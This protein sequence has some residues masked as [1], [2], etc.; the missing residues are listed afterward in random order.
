MREGGEDAHKIYP[1]KNYLKCKS[2]HILDHLSLLCTPWGSP[3]YFHIWWTWCFTFSF[4][5]ARD[6]IRG[7]LE[8]F[9][10]PFKEDF[11][12]SDEGHQVFCK[13]FESFLFPPLGAIYMHHYWLKGHFLF[14]FFRTQ[15][16]RL[17]VWQYQNSYLDLAVWRHCYLHS[18]TQQCHSIIF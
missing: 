15:W 5:R 3:D 16:T 1:Q 12:R 8:H 9:H 4:W 14:S 10:F 11:S 7:E 2:F 13:T 18:T 17:L 6:G